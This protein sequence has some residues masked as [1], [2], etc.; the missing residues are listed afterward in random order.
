MFKE[1][2]GDSQIPPSID[3]HGL[4]ESEAD[5]EEGYDPYNSIGNMK[6]PSEKWSAAYAA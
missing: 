5:V 1:D 4:T 3:N 2:T 6:P